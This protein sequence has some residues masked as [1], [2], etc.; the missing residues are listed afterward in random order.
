MALFKSNTMTQAS[1]SVGGTT[2]TRTKGGM[3][4]R[5]R[6]VP[7]N[8][9]TGKQQTVRS[10]LT[11]LVTRWTETLTA[12]QRTGWNTYASNVT[13]VNKLGDSTTNTGQN[14][15]VAMNTPRVQAALSIID[16]A[17][18]VFDRGTFSDPAT[19]AWSVASGLTITL[20]AGD[21]WA[22]AAGNYMLVYMGIPKNAS[23]NYF[24]GPYRFLTSKQG[25]ATPPTTITATAAAVAAAGFPIV[26]GQAI[27][28]SLAVTR[29]D[30]RL[31]TRR[32]YGPT[33]AVA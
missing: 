32:N 22:A 2:Y 25:N 20:T 15:Y 7:T 27:F 6:S 31:S 19:F 8:P 11:Q 16:A 18:A 26:L 21:A 1:G 29:S 9:N 13:V 24:K 28:C 23:V 10:N 3:T 17:P 33:I 4:M 14:W 5:A 30:G 12:A